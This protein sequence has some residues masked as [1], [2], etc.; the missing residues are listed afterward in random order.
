MFE[1]GDVFMFVCV[2]LC[3]VVLSCV[4]FVVLLFASVLVSMRW[5]L[6]GSDGSEEKT[7]SVISKKMSREGIYPH[8][9]LN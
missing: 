4:V 1:K 5:L 3:V 2:W 7:A 9:G 8:Y 6:C